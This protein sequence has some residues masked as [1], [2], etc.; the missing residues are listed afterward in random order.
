MPEPTNDMFGETSELDESLQD[1]I[2]DAEDALFDEALNA[3][4]DEGDD[5]VKEAIEEDFED[6]EESPAN[7]LSEEP[8]YDDAVNDAAQEEAQD[9]FEAEVQDDYEE[10]AQDDYD[11]TYTAASYHI[12]EEAEAAEEL[13][14]DKDGVLTPGYDK[15]EF[16]RGSSDDWVDDNQRDYYRYGDKMHNVRQDVVNTDVDTGGLGRHGVATSGKYQPLNEHQRRSR[17]M[18]RFLTVVAVLLI[19]LLI[20]LGYFAW[21]LLRESSNLAAE[22]VAAPAATEIE[23]AAD[24]EEAT[25]ETETAEKKTEVPTLVPLLNKTSADALQRLGEGAIVTLDTTVDE[26][27]NPVK[28]RQNVVLTNEPVDSKSGTPTV[29]LGM[30]AA[31]TVIQVGY[32]AATT[33]LGYGTMSFSDA[34]TSGHIIEQTL[35]ETIILKI[36]LFV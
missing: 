8:A 4:K 11:S 26:E 24:K 29:Y 15:D 34:V 25:K 9:A 35:R 10:E 36:S 32:S 27:G 22:Q 1:S 31:G 20:G 18:R 13:P 6:S 5:T 30:D 16:L 17:K 7:E 33:S 28:Q 19:A 14:F 23:A 3:A 2:Q 21:Q 12:D